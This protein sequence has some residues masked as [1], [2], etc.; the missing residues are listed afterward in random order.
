MPDPGSRPP[1]PEDATTTAEFV[2]ALRKLRQWSGLTYRELAAQAAE[3]GDVLPP[4]TMAT[5]LGRAKLPREGFVTAFV[6]ACGFDEAEAARW[7]TARKA[8]AAGTTPA[9]AAREEPADAPAATPPADETLTVTALPGDDD[10]DDD[11]EVRHGS[12]PRRWARRGWLQTSTIV[13]VTA[14]AMV[15]VVAL[16]RPTGGGRT[17]DGDQASTATG[18]RTTKALT[19]PVPAPSAGPG[20]P[21]NGWYG[22]TPSHVADRDLCVGEGRE[23]NQRTNRPIAV[24]RPCDDLSPDTYLRVDDQGAYAIEWHDPKNGLG[25]LSVD[26]GYKGANALIQPTDCRDDAPYQRFMLEQRGDGFRLRPVHSGACL[27]A[28]NGPRDTEVG[29]ELAQVACEDRTDQIVL[30]RPRPAPKL[31]VPL[32]N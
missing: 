15:I 23:R 13:S 10:A 7:V 11:G 31:P 21:S 4:S 28:L 1:R 22:L 8:L 29:G 27:G 2:A 14:I 5:V 12:R 26:E 30:I 16:T 18:G 25:C 9:P 20:L 32:P 19:N 17:P 6:R 3:A 24:Q